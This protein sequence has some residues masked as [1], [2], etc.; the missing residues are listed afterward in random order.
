[1]RFSVQGGDAEIPLKGGIMEITGQAIAWKVAAGIMGIVLPVAVF[2]IWKKK[3]VRIR[4]AVVGAVVFVV[5]S[6]VLEG[7]PK[8]IFFNGTTELSKY[9]WW[10]T[11]AYVLIGCLQAGIFE[12]T[13]RFVAFRFFLKKYDDPRDS[14]TYGI[15]HGGIESIIV[16]GLT[17]LSSIAMAA[18]V[19]SGTLEQSLAGLGEAQLKSVEMQI[20]ALADY[21]FVRMILEVSERIVAMALHISLSVVVFYGVR[22]SRLLYLFIAMI[23]HAVFD[24]PAALYQCRPKFCFLWKPFC[25]RFM[26]SGYTERWCGNKFPT[27]FYTLKSPI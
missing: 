21:G 11:W 4:P 12:E 24:V 10:H 25:V 3:D 16:L 20:S 17:A 26:R 22:R 2:L 5:F 19:N 15:G 27:P 1:M 7:I 23:F 18:A 9:V 13:G 14:V 8:L 6:Q